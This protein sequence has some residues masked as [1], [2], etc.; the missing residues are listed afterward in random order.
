MI[1]AVSN[2]VIEIISIIPKGIIFYFS[3]YKL[4]HMCYNEW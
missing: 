4:M 2:K 1:K 3:N